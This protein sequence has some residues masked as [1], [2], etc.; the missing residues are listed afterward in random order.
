MSD[1]TKAPKAGEPVEI[2]PGLRRILAPNPSPM[3]YWGTNTYLLGKNEVT[4]VDPGPEN[5]QHLDAIVKACGGCENIIQILVT[6]AHRDHSP[7]AGVLSRATGAPVL[8]FGDAQAGRNEVRALLDIGGGEGVDTGFQPDRTLIDAEVI[9]SEIGAVT[10]LWTPGHFGNHMCFALP[11]GILFTGD[12]VMGWATSL[13]SP[14][15]GDLGA[16]LRSLDR[17]AARTEDRLY[18]PGHGA[19]MTTPHARLAELR[20]HRL[21]RHSQIRTALLDEPGTATE[22]AHRIYTEIDRDLLPAAAR[23]VLAHLLEMAS[24]N[25]ATPEGVLSF[26]TRFRIVK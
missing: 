20:D 2:A 14:P 3:T 10:A 9:D 23:N 16:F 19:P 18:L 7:G 12:L 21:M 22:L 13:V 5:A 8:A 24:Q 26:S 1:Q 15:D 25:E 4:I 11:D 6:H 17:L